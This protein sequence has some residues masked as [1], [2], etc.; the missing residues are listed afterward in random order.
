MRDGNVAM[1]RARPKADFIHKSHENFESVDLDVFHEIK[2]TGASRRHLN[3]YRNMMVE[4][5]LPMLYVQI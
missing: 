2:S 4:E 1:G 3:S 5:S